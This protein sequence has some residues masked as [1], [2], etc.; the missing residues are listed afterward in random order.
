M[1]KLLL[2]LTIM[3]PRLL[4]ASL[5][6]ISLALAGVP[7]EPTAKTARFQGVIEMKIE[8]EKGSGS[9]RLS[10]SGEEG[11]PA[12]LE[13]DAAMEGMDQPFRMSVIQSG[14]PDGSLLL[15]DQRHKLYS[16]MTLA[17]A[18]RLASAAE[19]VQAKGK[20]KVKVLGEGKVLGYPCTH[21]ALTRD[22]DLI[23]AWVT[24]DLADVY[25]LLRKLQQAN[26]KDPG[27][28]AVFAALEQAGHAGLPM[29]Y[30]V[31]RDGQ[32]VTTEVS[33]VERKAVPA[34]EFVLPKDF[35]RFEAAAPAA[36][37]KP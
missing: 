4:L 3:G 8:M 17:E 10:I 26:S 14:K 24:R 1:D 34:S 27:A 35:R 12:K 25:G 20:Y 23:D 32:K 30:T 2:S 36:A 29:R 11:A 18:A 33:K 6:S 31:I 16:E 15:V 5:F 37:A 28:A 19:G 13:M 22:K 9:M 21:V 7:A